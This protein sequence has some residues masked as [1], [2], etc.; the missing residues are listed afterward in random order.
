[1][2]SLVPEHIERQIVAV[3]F[4][5][6]A[7]MNW[8]HMNLSQRSKQYAGWVSD[9]RVGGVLKAFMAGEEA[10]VWI[11]DGPMKEFSRACSGQ[12]KYAYLIVDPA[13]SPQA[14]V[15]LALGN[16]WRITP[17]SQRIKPLRVSALSSTSERI[18]FAWGPAKDF[19]HLLWAALSSIARNENLN[20]VLCL[21]A[22]FVSPTPSDLRAHNERL[23]DHCGVRVVH[24]SIPE[25][26]ND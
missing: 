10:R 20:W 26:N 4:A 12:G 23:A 13:P 14:L 19:K 16:D 15:R 6:A 21:T 3:L 17:G 18:V 9:L 5:D 7:C 25:G 11:K 22:P 8:Q 1:M 2:S 24:L